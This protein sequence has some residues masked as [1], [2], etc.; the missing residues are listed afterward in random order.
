[1]G[2]VVCR[3]QDSR[4]RDGDARA[5]ATV[6]LGRRAA[7]GRAGAAARGAVAL[8]RAGYLGDGP[9]A[10]AAA[11]PRGTAAGAVL[12][13]LRSPALDQLE[14]AAR[15]RAGA[16]PSVDRSPGEDGQKAGCW[17]WAL[18]TRAR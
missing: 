4:G 8:L 2:A 14:G 18:A 13:P 17:S 15:Q 3:S 6:V 5:D 16:D 1:A 9:D 11:R 7:P 10:R 12:A